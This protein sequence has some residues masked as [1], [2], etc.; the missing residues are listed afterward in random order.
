M[1][2]QWEVFEYRW[3]DNDSLHDCLGAIRSD[4][5]AVGV[6]S[7][8]EFDWTNSAEDWWPN[9]RGIGSINGAGYAGVV[10]GDHSAD[11]AP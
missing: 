4:F 7:G 11:F 5:G 2:L 1:G 9:L 6:S 8:F 3:A 10:D